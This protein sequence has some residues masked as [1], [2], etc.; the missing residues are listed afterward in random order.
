MKRDQLRQVEYTDVDNTKHY[1]SKGLNVQ[2]F[3]G[4]FHG[5]KKKFT[6]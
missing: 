6:K 2:N 4:Y 3:V 1:T 5:W